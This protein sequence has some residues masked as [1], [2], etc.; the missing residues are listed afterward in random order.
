M[1]ADRLNFQKNRLLIILFLILLSVSL[2][3]ALGLGHNLTKRQVQ[4][5][6]NSLKIDILEDSMS[7]YEAFF[8]QTIPE[9]SYYQGFLD[10]LS[11]AKYAN[12][13]LDKY[14]FV[15]TI[16]FYD[17]YVSNRDI[18]HGIAVRNL[19]IG[20]KSVYKF[21]KKVP[22]G[23]R[24]IYDSRKPGKLSLSNADEFNNI[25]LKM[26]AF[27]ESAD[28]T[29]NVSN[30]TIFR[31]FYSIS[32]NRISYMNVPRRQEISAF[33]E[34][35][36]NPN[37]E[38]PVYE[39]DLFSFE[40]NPHKLK[41]INRHPNLYQNISIEELSFESIFENPN[42]LNTGMPLPGAFSGYKLYFTSSKLYLKKEVNR[43]FL[44][45]A[46]GVFFIYATMIVI[47]FL[48]YRNFRMS[49][50]LFKLQY[51][52]V[53]NLTHEFKTPVAVIKIAGNNI[54]SAHELSMQELNHYGKI[55]DEEADKLNELMNK[56]LSFT[57]IENKTINIKQVEI[58]LEEFSQ[59]IIN[60]YQLKYP[61]YKIDLDVKRSVKTFIS[62]PVLLTS[63][64]QNLIE[65][66]YKYSNPEQKY[67]KITVSRSKKNIV[68]S[69]K[70]KG[71]GIRKTEIDNIFKKFYRIESQYN[72]QGS[73][74]L[75]LAFCKELVNLMKGNITVNSKVGKGSEFIVEL[76]YINK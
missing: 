63:I 39:Q 4:S 16:T 46:F 36:N 2:I 53:N 60:G 13:V 14:Q 32:P 34:I 24:V 51:D 75:G 10:S 43:R 9:I 50:K 33:Q 29:K 8:Q 37:K 25:G 57:Q 45:I 68:F 17:S 41:I 48:I 70:D 18:L 47:T 19:G 27:I 74:G 73:I 55:L 22:P 5:E 58:E 71:I 59:N 40:L 21:G 28:T 23:S 67:L 3:V 62:D 15:E 66:A 61:D 31:T 12:S 72:Q 38:Y 42:Y 54:R 6:F 26:A 69:F 35:M 52:F 44:P 11:A 56:L 20:I 64:Y 7:P 65:N 30:E 76:P 49:R 1:R